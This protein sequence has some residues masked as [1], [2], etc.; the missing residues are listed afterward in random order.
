MTRL[1]KKKRGG[2]NKHCGVL[3]P[4]DYALHFKKINNYQQLEKKLI[5]QCE[6]AKEEIKGGKIDVE[7][8]KLWEIFKEGYDIAHAAKAG[9]YYLCLLNTHYFKS[10]Y[11][12][13]IKNPKTV[14][15]M[16]MGIKKVKEKVFRDQS[17]DFHDIYIG[18]MDFMDLERD[19]QYWESAWSR[20]PIFDLK[21]GKIKKTSF[22]PVCNSNYHLG[23]D[24][25]FITAGDNQAE[26]AEIYRKMMCVKGG[27]EIEEFK[28]N[29]NSIQ[30]SDGHGHKHG[31]KRKSKKRRKSRRKS[32][33][34]RKKTKKRR[35]RRRR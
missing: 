16:Y 33:K 20:L 30:K 18:L 34:R 1:S 24:H 32:K 15:L 6:L 3:H 2:T 13:N 22:I 14:E 25:S 17:A 19:G 31:G 5:D 7:F 11:G 10:I 23:G 4:Q 29:C 35:R 8:Y 12:Y 28:D 9:S 26:A 21:D 27:E